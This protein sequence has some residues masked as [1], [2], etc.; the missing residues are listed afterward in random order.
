MFSFGVFQ[1][2]GGLEEYS[3]KILQRIQGVSLKICS[4]DF[5][6]L[7]INIINNEMN[8]LF[9]F[10][11]AKILFTKEFISGLTI[12]F[13]VYLGTIKNTPYEEK[14]LLVE[15]YLKKLLEQLIQYEKYKNSINRTIDSNTTNIIPIEPDYL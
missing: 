11:L 9:G 8:S 10:N 15:N 2:D 14:T 5:T 13:I 12:S 6:E 1:K 7:D 3:N 4:L